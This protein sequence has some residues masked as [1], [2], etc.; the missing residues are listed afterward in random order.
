MLGFLIP[1][2][3]L[4]G[5]GFGFLSAPSTNSYRM[6]AGGS[7]TE[8]APAQGKTTR[9]DV[10]STSL[11]SSHKSL[12]P[13][14]V[15]PVDAEYTTKS[16]A[17]KTDPAAVENGTE[18]IAVQDL[19][20]GRWIAAADI[21]HPRHRHTATLLKDGRVL[22]AGGADDKWGESTLATCEIYD[23]ATGQWSQ[24]A[25]MSTPRNSHTA[26][27]LKDGRVLVAGGYGGAGYATSTCE[28]YD[29][30]SDR[31]T[32]IAPML[33]Q[34]FR[35]QMILLNDDSVLVVGGRR[36]NIDRNDVQDVWSPLASCEIYSISADKWTAAGAMNQI[37]VE[38]GIGLLP[39]GR[40]LV[41]GGI[42]KLD[43]VGQ[44]GHPSITTAS[45]EIYDPVTNKWS[46]T[47]AF[48]SARNFVRLIGLD[49][50]EIL[51]VGGGF[52]T[53]A[54]RSCEI[55]TGEM[56]LWRS[57]GDL[58]EPRFVAEAVRLPNGDI[59]TVG[60]WN[61]VWSSQTASAELYDVSTGRWAALPSMATERGWHTATL[62]NTG[63]IL[64][65]GG[66]SQA[67]EALKSCE[68]YQPE[69]DPVYSI[70]AIGD[71][72][73]DEGRSVRVYWIGHPAD[74][75]PTPV[76]RIESYRI[77]CRDDKDGMA[78]ADLPQGRWTLVGTVSATGRSRYS[79]V[80]PTGA[81][82]SSTFV[83]VAVS[84]SA[85]FATVQ[86]SGEAFD[87]CGP[88]PVRGLSVDRIDGGFQLRWSPSPSPDVRTYAIYRAFDPTVTICPENLLDTTS[89]MSY[90]DSVSVAEPLFYR[91][92]AIDASGNPG[93]ANLPVR[94]ALS[95]VPDRE[96]SSR[97]FALGESYPQ[98]FMDK[99]TIPITLAADAVVTVEIY[100]AQ[101]KRVVGPLQLN[102]SAGQREIH[103]DGGSLPSGDYSCVVRL[104]DESAVVPLV[105][106]R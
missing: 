50:N 14:T 28:I 100:D 64:V 24:A 102:L 23:P 35:H 56:D 60:G 12:H 49:N 29:P 38:F 8:A 19:S 104:G 44:A 57:T 63:E 75:S 22:V 46:Y 79:A 15:I 65:V 77:Y 87:N 36:G 89:N 97:T 98:P 73:R 72:P 1:I 103:L 84:A 39:D 18:T 90:I 78:V 88:A 33:T 94:A 83:V 26:T 71:V 80:V 106:R 74:I 54:L 66:T 55:F 4:I 34:R 3:A 11:L 37:R 30:V 27:L 6:V 16:D 45:C 25:S 82:M 70:F 48:Q 40:V 9:A 7:S 62:L 68:I 99:V 85:A 86:A 52:A 13:S 41:A 93:V 58:N 81:S 21:S 43:V 59:M 10:A 32:T 17:D 91:V 53:D 51:S 2:V 96:A 67:N 105:R 20:H 76:D 31:W 42:D 92:R 47:D 61:K 101:S 95:L 69:S 5:L